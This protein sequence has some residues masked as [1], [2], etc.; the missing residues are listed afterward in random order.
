[1][2][3][4]LAYIPLALL[5]YFA[6][7]L[8]T[9]C[10]KEYSY[11]G[12]QG[13][14]STSGTAIYTFTG[15]GGTCFGYNLY[16]N[17]YAGT[18]TDATD[19]VVLQVNV[20]T[21]GTYTINTTSV[22]GFK[23]ARSGTFINTGIQT[24]AL[25]ASGMP[26]A[27]GLTSFKTPVGAGCG[28]SVTVTEAPR[29]QAGY[30][31]SGSPGTCTIARVQGEYIAG[32]A[33]NSGNLVELQVDVVKPGDYVISTDTL[34]NI[35]FSAAGTF[36]KGGVQTI[37][38]AGNGTP[39]IPDSLLFTP[40]S[41]TAAGCTFPV[42]VLTPQP[43]ATYVLESGFGEVCI[44]LPSGT[45]QAGQAMTAGNFIRVNIYVTV[46][47]NYTVATQTL[48]GI[49]FYATGTFTNLG[50]QSLVLQATGN[51]LA[52][53]SFSYTPKI[54]GPHPLGGQACS[55]PLTVL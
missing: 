32:A 31:F 29:P 46:L 22:N 33:L 54:I 11:E 40:K 45:Y 55:F 21:A 38:L 15:T 7:L 14:A 48:N 52:A 19:S 28:F 35:Y 10:A 3:K 12:G 26:S 42:A 30:V 39:G 5:L 44:G 24:V 9:R 4:L 37:T 25:T 6:V 1:M 51:P 36:T 16:G 2:R 50:A 43:P 34:D 8:L 47:G 49:R 27:L 20:T 41:T 13:L 18:A 17:Y 53:G 23:F